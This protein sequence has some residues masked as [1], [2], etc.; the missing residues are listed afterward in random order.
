MGWSWEFSPT[1]LSY[2]KFRH[3]N[4]DITRINLFNTDTLGTKSF[5]C[6][7]VSIFTSP[8]LSVN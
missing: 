6:N 7:K 3:E 1:I 4:I 5:V 2:F 8:E